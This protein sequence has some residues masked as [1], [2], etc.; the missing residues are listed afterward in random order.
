MTD[1]E[2]QGAEFGTLADIRASDP[3]KIAKRPFNK[4]E[5]S[6]QDLKRRNTLR[7]LNENYFN[8]NFK[9]EV[10]KP[11]DEESTN[12]VK[13]ELLEVPDDFQIM[14]TRPKS[15]SV[16]NASVEH[17]QYRT[18]SEQGRHFGGK[19]IGAALKDGYMDEEDAYAKNASGMGRTRGLSIISSEEKSGDSDPDR[20]YVMDEKTN[21]L[22]P[23]NTT[24][25]VASGNKVD[26]FND[27]DYYKIFLETSKEQE[28][29]VKKNSPFS[30]LRTWRLMKVIVKTNDDLRQE[31]FAM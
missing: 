5:K 23:K 28:K 8:R 17:Q 31:A 2:K 15:N 7:L 25:E 12:A 27:R 3:V 11:A 22:I 4:K 30:K 14:P 18:N 26:F 24:E 21:L 20:S 29:R 10:N 1:I 19:N 16:K 9:T 13:K 6:K